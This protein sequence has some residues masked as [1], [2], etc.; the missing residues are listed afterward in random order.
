MIAKG[1]SAETLFFC[2]AI[3]G[4]FIYFYLDQKEKKYKKANWNQHF[5]FSSFLLLF[6]FN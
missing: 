4:L 5:F 6:I 3:L 2:W 1:E